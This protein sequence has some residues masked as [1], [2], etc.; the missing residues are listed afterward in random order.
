MINLL[1]SFKCRKFF[2]EN[3]DTLKATNNYFSLSV[4]IFMEYYRKFPPGIY[5]DLQ[6]LNE[7]LLSLLK[8]CLLKEVFQVVNLS[9]MIK[10]LVSN[11]RMLF[12]EN[13]LN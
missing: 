7:L 4:N 5:F 12:L 9:I 10:M 11:L 1:L 6:V 13:T 2:L 8:Y 3:V